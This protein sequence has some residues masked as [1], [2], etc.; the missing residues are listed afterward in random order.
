MGNTNNMEETLL[1]RRL[2]EGDE[3]AFTLLYN[4]YSPVLYLNILKLVK[5]EETAVD[6]LQ[7]LF[8][9]I[10]NHRQSINPDKEFRAYLFR[11]TYNLVRDF[12]RKAAREKRLEEQ[13]V[14]LTTECYEHI[15]QLLQQKETASILDKAIDALPMQQRRI[16]ILCRVEGRSYE[17][18]AAMLQLSIA[19]IGN[20]LSKATKTIRNRLNKRDLSYMLAVVITANAIV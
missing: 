7:E 15:E 9:K 16:F 3:Q 8:I 14:A 1:T 2:M 4:K 20:Q 5:A 19:T 13:L 12:F 11:I 18:V 17:E 10:W 6:L